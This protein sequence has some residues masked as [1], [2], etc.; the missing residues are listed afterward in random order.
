M[1][2]VIPSPALYYFTC[3]EQCID[4]E[5]LTSMIRSCF[6]VQMT[7]FQLALQR[8]AAKKEKEKEEAERK[9]HQTREVNLFRKPNDTQECLVVGSHSQCVHPIHGHARPRLD[10]T[11]QSSKLM[12][13]CHCIVGAP[14][15]RAQLHSGRTDFK[16]LSKAASRVCCSGIDIWSPKIIRFAVNRTSHLYLC[17]CYSMQELS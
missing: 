14:S 7:S 1:T 11:S 17:I 13:S 3:S 15:G 9:K 8:E 6:P 4:V 16:V 2:W 10:D 5:D 12:S